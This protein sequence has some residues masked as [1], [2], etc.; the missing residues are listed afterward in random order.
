MSSA[1]LVVPRSVCRVRSGA[2]VPVKPGSLAANLLLSLLLVRQA[3]RRFAGRRP[4]GI[5]TCWLRPPWF[6]C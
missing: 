6:W 4:S 3:A 2:K 1:T 5:S